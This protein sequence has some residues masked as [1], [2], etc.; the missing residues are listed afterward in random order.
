MRGEDVWN[1]LV[2]G[3]KKEWKR[4]KKDFLISGY[5]QRNN[6]LI[7]TVSDEEGENGGG[8]LI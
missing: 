1:D 2:R 3:E 5:S 4:V 8:E 7:I 6:L